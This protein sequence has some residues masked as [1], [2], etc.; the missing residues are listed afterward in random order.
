MFPEAPNP[1]AQERGAEGCACTALS[2]PSKDAMYV[3]HFLHQTT[4]RAC[5]RVESAVSTGAP[6]S[7]R[8]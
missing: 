2:G 4:A 7:C 6:G 5:M 8:P 3:P 1:L